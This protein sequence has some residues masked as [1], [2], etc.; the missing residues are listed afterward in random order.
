LCL[1][2]TY[3]V[4]TRAPQSKKP[5]GWAKCLIQLVPAAAF[6]NLRCVDINILAIAINKVWEGKN[7]R[8]KLKLTEEIMN[9]LG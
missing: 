8:I 1:G 4:P 5:V 3:V 7:L 9:G 2:K 6:V